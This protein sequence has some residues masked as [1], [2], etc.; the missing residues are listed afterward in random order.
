MNAV[1]SRSKLKIVKPR[2]FKTV[3]HVGNFKIAM[4]TYTKLFVNKTFIDPQM[5]LYRVLTMINDTVKPMNA[6]PD[7]VAKPRTL[8]SESI[9]YQT[10][11]K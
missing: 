9:P 6:D 8:I 1:L 5:L 2:T 7:V 10:V 4:N 3:K 11:S